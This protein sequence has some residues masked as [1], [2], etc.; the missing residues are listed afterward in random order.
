LG[1]SRREPSKALAFLARLANE[2][3]TV[4]NLPNLLEHV[5]AVLHE[6]IGF[7]SCTVALTVEH[8]PEALVVRAAS[9]I[10]RNYLGLHIPRGEGLHGAVMKT[11]APLLIPDMAEDPRVYRRESNIRSGIYAPLAVEGR[12][13]GV[14]SA[15]R[16]EPNAFTDADFNLLTIVAGYLA[17]AIEVARLHEQIKEAA[18]TDPLT[19]LANRRSFLDRLAVE[20]ARL[21]RTDGFLSVSLLDLNH[22]KLI[23]DTHGHAVG[24]GALVTVAQMLRSSIR[25]SDL[26][27]RFGGDEFTLLLPDT[28]GVQAKE[29]VDRIGVA[30]VVV[31]DERSGQL[32]VT[33]SWGVATWPDDGK[34][35]ESVLRAADGRLYEM[36]TR[37]GMLGPSAPQA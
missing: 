34:D 35:A 9:G 31:Q 20:M 11:G 29:I 19:G 37:G 2:F 15:H 36:K 28:T 18:A 12:T 27:A 7:D 3:T 14:L 1:V 10:R 5:M 26:A 6:E 24:D 23:N 32:S 4:L 17:G 33:F 30:E 16:S 22:L 25:A 21:R 8:D 13:V